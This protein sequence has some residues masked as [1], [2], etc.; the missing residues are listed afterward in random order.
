LTVFGKNNYKF[1][2]FHKFNP[3]RIYL[4]KFKPEKLCELKLWKDFQP[5]RER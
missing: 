5:T 2:S 1:S 4:N 3:L